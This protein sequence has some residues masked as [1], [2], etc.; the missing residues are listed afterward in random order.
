MTQIQPTPRVLKDMLL[1]LGADNFELQ[2]AEA[3][4]APTANSQSWRAIGGNKT[5]SD[6]DA[7]VWALTIRLAQDHETAGSLN[8]YLYDNEGTKQTAILKPV[9]GSGSS[10]QGIVTITPAGI[11]GAAGT[12]AEGTVALP[13]DGKP[14]RIP[15]APSIPIM[16][17]ATPVS[18]P[19]AGGTMVKITGSKF[20][21][22]T[23]VHFGTTLVPAA[24]WTLVSD[25]LIVAKTPAQAAGSK[26]AKVTNASGQSSTA[27]P[28]SYV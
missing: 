27:A 23:A 11:G 17:L 9:S 25:T 14:T 7:A 1:Q 5:Y 4:W 18:G 15:S 24:D 22:A 6:V 2:V 20:T 12:W 19:A 13:T 16:S 8:D 10:Y 3:T 28:Y 21:G 26:P